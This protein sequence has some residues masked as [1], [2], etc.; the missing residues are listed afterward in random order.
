MTSE[1][2]VIKVVDWVGKKLILLLLFFYYVYPQALNTFGH[3]FVFLSGIVGAGVYVYHRFPFR[4]VVYGC[5]ALG[6]MVFIQFY[7]MYANNS[8]DPY[9]QSYMFSHIASFFSCYLLV[10]ILF[11]LERNVTAITL[12][13]YIVAAV[14]IQA[15]LSLLMYNYPDIKE[16][17]IARELSGELNEHNRAAAEGARL[18][19]HGMGFFGAG[20]VYGYALIIMAYIIATSRIKAIY[21]PLL[22][23]VYI[24][25]FYIG[26]FSARTTIIG[27]AISLGLILAYLILHYERNKTSIFVFMG[28]AIVAVV[29]GYGLMFQFFPH[30]AG[31]AFELWDNYQSTGQLWTRSSNGLE[32]MF[33]FPDDM[34]TFLI[35]NGRM[36]FWGN[37]VGFTRLAF[38]SGIIGMTA[39]LLFPFIIVCFSLT[40]DVSV[41]LLLLVLYGFQLIINIKGLTDLNNIF[42]LY[43]FFFC[44]YKYY[45]YRAGLYMTYKDRLCGQD[46][47]KQNLV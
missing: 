14:F 16:F 15:V 2:P 46:R 3:S 8:E 11:K 27:G 32:E 24:F 19:G 43:F 45:V 26:I 10:L 31:W 20:V 38:F 47:I 29:L 36:W 40:R 42:Y 22:T 7:T 28:G 4:E 5:V 9:I 33:Y 34:R 18:I 44:Y 1:S 30:M 25:L 6:V 12:S 37:D 23:I 13:S 21:T 35:G 41:N 17:L 39:Y